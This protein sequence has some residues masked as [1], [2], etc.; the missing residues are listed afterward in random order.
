[1]KPPAPPAQ[2]AQPPLLAWLT[3]RDILV[4]RF[5]LAEVLGP[6]RGAAWA[7]ACRAPARGGAPPP[8]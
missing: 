5:V 7:R 3:R 6:P 1:M 4:R 2:K 8:K